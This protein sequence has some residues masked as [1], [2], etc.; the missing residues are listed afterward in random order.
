MGAEAVL[1]DHF[2]HVGQDLG[3]GCDGRAGPGLEAVAEG[4]QVA[5][6]ADAGI[7]MRPPRAA[8]TVQRLQD[9]EALAGALL[10]EV[11]GRADA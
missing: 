11:I 4:M 1:L 2:A 10:G 5:V 6:G 9:H 8:E 3:R 7:A